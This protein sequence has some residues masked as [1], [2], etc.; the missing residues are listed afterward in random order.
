[1]HRRRI[2]RGSSGGGS[3]RC[4]CR[5]PRGGRR[6]GLR[7]R[8]ERRGGGGGTDGKAGAAPEASFRPPSAMHSRLFQLLEVRGGLRV[9]GVEGEDA[10]E[11]AAGGGRL[12]PLRVDHGEVAEG[13]HV[14]GVV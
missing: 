3:L 14:V 12:A 5:G 13:R 8:R 9:A 6:R 4:S 2:R 7:R 10:L 11:E 1:D